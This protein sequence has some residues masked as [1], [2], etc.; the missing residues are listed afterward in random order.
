MKNRTVMIIAHRL[1][2]VRDA[3]V[4]AVFGKGSIES[5][6]THDELLLKSQTYANLVKK[7]LSGAGTSNASLSGIAGSEGMRQ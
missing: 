7:Q 6:G 4:I 3:D 5:L 2:T 1:S